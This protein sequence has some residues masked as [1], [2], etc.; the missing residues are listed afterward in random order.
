LV[1]AGVKAVL[2]KLSAVRTANDVGDDC[3]APGAFVRQAQQLTGLQNELVEGGDVVFRGALER[4]SIITRLPFVLQSCDFLHELEQRRLS[5][6]C[7]HDCFQ[8]GL[9]IGEFLAGVTALNFLSRWMVAF[10]YAEEPGF[11]AAGF[12]GGR[13]TKAA[14]G[15]FDGIILGAFAAV[16]ALVGM[17]TE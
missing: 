5:Y 12:T 1:L 9:V 8:R 17:G 11:V 2:A 14:G 15:V 13:F 16:D 6:R 3:L 4:V 10:R 7:L